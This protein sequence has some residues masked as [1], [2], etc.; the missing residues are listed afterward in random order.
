MGRHTVKFK[1]HSC[2]HCCTDVICLPSPWDVIRMVREVGESPYKFLEFI[3]PDDIDGVEDDDP[4]WLEVGEE[5]YMM[6]LKRG[7]KGCH[8]LDK[9]TKFC[10]IYESRPLLCRLFPFKLEESRTGEFKGFTLHNDVGCPRN[11]DGVVDT[12][13]L[14]EIYRED[15]K[16]HKDYDALVEA[17]NEMD[18]P[19]KK[20]EDFIATFITLKKK[21]KTSR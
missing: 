2:G 4:T 1:C 10:T 15:S 11:R 20:P 8:F 3:E 13:P 17:F 16:H 19:D 12:E 9:K 7:K 18:Y 5:R 6:A 14:Y 21:K